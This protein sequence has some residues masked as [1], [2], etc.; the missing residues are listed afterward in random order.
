MCDVVG[1]NQ[2]GITTFNLTSVASI[3]LAAQPG[4]PAQYAITY[5][6]TE[7]LAQQGTLGNIVNPA[8]Y[9]NTTPFTQ[10]IW[11]RVE[12]LSSPTNCFAIL[13][14]VL[15]VNTPLVAT[16]QVMSVCDSLPND[17][18]AQFDLTINNNAFTGGN[19]NLYTLS[20]YLNING[21]ITENPAA[22][23]AN[24]AQF[25]NTQQGVQTLGVVITDNATGCKSRSI[26]NIRVEP[27]P[28]ADTTPDALEVCDDDSDGIALFDLTESI[29]DIQDLDAA[30]E[31]TFHLTQADAEANINAIPT[32]DITAYASTSTTLY[33]RVYNPNRVDY[34]GQPCYQ[35][36]A[37]EL[38][39]NPL[40]TIAANPTYAICEPQTDN[41]ATFTLNT[42]ND[43]ILGATQALADYT[44]R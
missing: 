2:D 12:D 21:A 40:P 30:L 19:A 8:N 33:V 44:I 23:I 24:P 38:I 32:A 20:Y 7:A 9:Q 3:I 13:S 15:E 16:P 36:V 42:M 14:L 18:F 31:M 41:V 22:L 27:A 26:L 4:V 35:V 17:G 39:V 28:R 29:E 6:P 5:Y 37:L 1:N 25:T 10:T 11:I 34:T 43:E